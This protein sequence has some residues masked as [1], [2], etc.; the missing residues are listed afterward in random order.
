MDEVVQLIL[1]AH[2]G[3]L[4]GRNPERENTPKYIEEALVNFDV[5]IDLRF[6]N[7]SIWLGHDEADIEINADWLFK[8]S[9]KLWIHCKDIESILYLRRLD[10]NGQNLNYFGHDN[11][12]FV[13][14]SKN[15]LFCI[16]SKKLNEECVL[17]M[18][19]YFN[20]EY[21]NEKVLGILTDFPEKYSYI[22]E[23]S[24]E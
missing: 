4:N 21:K 20:F 13:L 12:D 7:N 8:N 18:P 19:E 1:I 5:E 9:S 14:T 11:D 17:V 23:N 22:N 3:N 2:R 15:N 16:P 6:R 24:V 10:P